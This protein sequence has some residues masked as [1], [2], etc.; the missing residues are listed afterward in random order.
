MK[1]LQTVKK[2]PGG[3]MVIPLLL[4]VIVNTLF[5]EFFNIGGFTAALWKTGANTLI[6]A[7]L[8]CNGAQIN[9]K[10]VGQPLIKGVLLTAS[11][12]LIGAILGVLINR[13][14][15]PWGIIGITPL[16]II[17]AITNSNGGLYAALAGEFGDSTDVGAVSILSI[18]DGPF[19]TMVALGVSGIASI[20]FLALVAVI[21]PILV[22]CILG[23]LDEDLR[24]FL[25]NGTS[26]LIPF[27]A[28]PLGA[29]LN[30]GQI[31]SAGLPGI[32]LGI[33]CTAATGFGGYFVM[34]LIRS[35]H[36]AA[37]AAIGTTAGNAAATPA[38]LAA[39]DSTLA[40]VAAISTVQVAAAI[41]VTAVLCPLLV[42]WL[43]KNDKVKA[44][45]QAA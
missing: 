4:G 24:K 9:V 3:L 6:A 20:P 2:V 34:K 1:I 36:P 26:V 22:G 19:L 15:G 45:P 38:A 7:F 29:G 14:W 35:K 5:P 41:I 8:F 39:V 37:G 32:V 27:F 12:F 31:I 28:F 33:V 21:I 25:A 40:P 42:T 17:G 11:K 16:A 44:A 30:F 18:N 23:N 10:Q 43:A 13:I